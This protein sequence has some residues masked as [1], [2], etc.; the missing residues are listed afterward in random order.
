MPI[1]DC[2]H[3]NGY[4]PCGKSEICDALCPHLSVPTTRVLIIHLEALGAVLR[5]TALLAAIKRKFPGCHLTWVTQKPGEQ[6]LQNN[7]LI[8]KVMTTSSDDLLALSALEFDVALVIDK[9]LKAAGVLKQTRADLVYGFRVEPT[10]GAVMPATSAATELWEI[11][12]SNQKKFFENTKSE[13]QL[14]HEALELGPWY[15]DEYVL[16]LSQSERLEAERRRS[17]WSGAGHV[18]VGINT[19]CSTVI[20]YKKL[21][22]DVHRELVRGLNEN[23]QYR[24]VLLGGREDGLRNQ[25]IA[26]GLDAI[27]SP[28]DQGLRDG[29]V[30]VAACD[31]V[32]S[33]DSLG[34]H[35]AIALKKWTVAWFGPTCAHEIDLFDRGVVVQTQASCSPCWKRSCQR[36]PMCYDLVSVDELI[37]GVDQGAEIL[38]M[39]ARLDGPDGAHEDH[40]ARGGYETDVGGSS[41]SP[42]EADGDWQSET[43]TKI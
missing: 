39:P 15:R 29:I 26:H 30:S 40:G 16:Q 42:L 33:G 7:P 17:M 1:T 4:K 6:L 5:S 8:D 2:R 3:F 12:L 23:P 35:M 24:V 14:A 20:P 32:V 36:A 18:V 22:I 37:E 34:M 41:D 43:E 10:T 21:P 11:G 9:G 27:Q 25:R 28:T 38:R 19:G 13:A 31:I